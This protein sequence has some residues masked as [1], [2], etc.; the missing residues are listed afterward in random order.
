MLTE[1]QVI[2]LIK[3]EALRRGYEFKEVGDEIKM[4]RPDG[5]VA[6]IA[7]KSKEPQ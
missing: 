2:D 6:L 1:A 5:T 4:I 3:D 7:K